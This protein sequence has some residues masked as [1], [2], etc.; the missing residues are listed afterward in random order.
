MFALKVCAG[1]LCYVSSLASF[2]F[3]ELDF[4]QF[5]RDSIPRRTSPVVLLPG[6]SHISMIIA[7]PIREPIYDLHQSSI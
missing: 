1:P 2:P 3:F 7:T 6:W 5:F 4:Q